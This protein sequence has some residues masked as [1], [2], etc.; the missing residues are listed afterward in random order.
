MSDTVFELNAKD[1]PPSI[2]ARIIGSIPGV[3]STCRLRV[4]QLDGTIVVA[5][6]DVTGTIVVGAV[7][8]FDAKLTL[9]E[10]DLLLEGQYLW[11]IQVESAVLEFRQ[12][13]EY[14]LNVKKHYVIG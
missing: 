1:S 4:D 14:T 2:R 9:V 3:D 13:V 11:T 6:R 8:Y 10:S 12:E 7:T 5:E